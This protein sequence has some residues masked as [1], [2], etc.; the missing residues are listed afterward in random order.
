MEEQQLIEKIIETI[1][2][3][4]NN[5]FTKASAGVLPPEQQEAL[6]RY[7]KLLTNYKLSMKEKELEEKIKRAE[8]A[9]ARLSTPQP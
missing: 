8:E 1:R 7:L 9:Y 4:V 6:D 5:I 2:R 3:D